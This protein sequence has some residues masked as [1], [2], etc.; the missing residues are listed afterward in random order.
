MLEM[1]MSRHGI[2]Y[3]KQWLL[4]GDCTAVYPFKFDVPNGK[5]RGEPFVGVVEKVRKNKY[6][7]ISYIINGREYMAE[8]LFP[9]NDE[10]KLKLPRFRK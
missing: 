7:R 9:A 10:S 6:G 4:V 8:E 5:R 3:K 2:D 1:A